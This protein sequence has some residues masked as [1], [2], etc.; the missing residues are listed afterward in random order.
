MRK[1]EILYGARILAPRFFQQKFTAEN[2]QI[3][4]NGFSAPAYSLLTTRYRLLATF[5]HRA[6]VERL[7]L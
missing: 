3:A 1:T 2:A 5:R 7:K 4:K 6:P